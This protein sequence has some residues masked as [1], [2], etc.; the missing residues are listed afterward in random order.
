MWE[1]SD[2]SFISDSTEQS[3]K[4]MVNKVYVNYR[5][6][7]RGKRTVPI[8]WVGIAHLLFKVTDLELVR[9]IIFFEN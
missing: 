7:R 8:A 6:L 3:A 4:D 1:S 9:G 5:M 2:C